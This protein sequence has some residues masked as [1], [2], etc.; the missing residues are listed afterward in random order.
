MEYKDVA[1]Q[2][3][4]VRRSDSKKNGFLSQKRC[5]GMLHSTISKAGNQH[6]VVFGKRERLCEEAGKIIDSLGRD[7]LHFRRFFFRLFEFGLANIQ[8]RQ[9]WRFVH[10]AKQ[11][12]GESKKIRADGT[13][14]GKSREALA[15]TSL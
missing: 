12:G 14:F 7:L 5:S 3:V 15:G 6:H 13:G 10:F 11:T 9:A 8:S 1:I 4:A 2:V